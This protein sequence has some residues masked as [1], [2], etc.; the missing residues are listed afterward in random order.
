MSL[1]VGIGPDGTAATGLLVWE[2]AGGEFASAGHVRGLLA[3]RG[4]I[5]RF[6]AFGVRTRHA[7]GIA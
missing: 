4:K 3:N 1:A 5:P 7:P 6:A 2:V